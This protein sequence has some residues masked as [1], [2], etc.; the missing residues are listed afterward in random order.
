MLL[1]CKAVFAGGIE[2]IPIDYRPDLGARD[3]L[4]AYGFVEPARVQGRIS[5]CAGVVTVSFA[6]D[7]R[8]RQ[9]CDRCAE[10]FERAYRFSGAYVLVQETNGD[11]PDDYIVLPDAQLDMDDLCESCIL[12]HMPSKVLCREDCKG[13]CPVCG[14]NLN[15]KTCS[16]AARSVDPRLEALRQL[17][18]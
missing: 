14:Q 9:D 11:I 2:E 13:L 16:C 12:L 6:V 3:A 5:N 7:A 4:A 1:D 17:L 18:E 8:L 10:P 15:V